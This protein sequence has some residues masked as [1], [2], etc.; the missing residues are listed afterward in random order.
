MVTE[1][2]TCQVLDEADR[3]LDMGFEEPV[4]FILS[5]TNKGKWIYISLSILVRSQI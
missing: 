1:V 5:N 4:R 3:M 2:P